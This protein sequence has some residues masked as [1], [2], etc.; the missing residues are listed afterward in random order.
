MPFQNRKMEEKTLLLSIIVP[1]YNVEK[2]L[3]KCIDSLLIQDLPKEQYEIILVDDGSPDRCGEI[4]DEYALKYSNIRVLHQENGGLSVA[5]NT[6]IVAAKGK[7]IQFV[8]ADD[9]L[10]PNVLGR[11]VAR[12]Q[13]D[14]LD[15][16]RFNYQNVN[17][18]YEVFE[19][20]KEHRP[21]TDYS[22]SLCTGLEF[23]NERLGYACYAVQFLIR[24]DLINDCL[25]KEHILFEDTQWTPRMLRRAQRV[26][27]TSDVVYNYLSRIG[28]ITNAE[29]IDKQ[30]KLV[31]SKILLIEDLKCQ[32]IDCSDTRWYEG[33][34]SGTV[35]S[36]IGLL[37]GKLFK[38]RHIY[39]KQ[40]K[41]LDVYPLVNY[42]ISKT[43]KRKVWFINI[44]P[45]FTCFI[46]KLFN[47]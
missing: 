29:G 38:D 46:L 8:D 7:Y 42:H 25:F 36:I 1:I 44:S 10:E 37:S 11:L 12:A 35:I 45:K 27:S 13:K 40:L 18:Q 30:R 26:S 41:G 22:E 20:Y 28:S 39:L 47:S 17:E 33:M 4:A 15:I 34:I 31:E 24:T 9:Y 6:G 23:L 14:N 19:P 5:R 2:Y 16:L 43:G 32:M 21:F 3:C